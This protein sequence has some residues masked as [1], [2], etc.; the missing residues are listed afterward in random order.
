[1]WFW[2]KLQIFSHVWRGAVQLKET[3]G[4][5]AVTRRG[6][7]VPCYTCFSFKC[8]VIWFLLIIW[9]LL[10]TGLVKTLLCCNIVNIKQFLTRYVVSQTAVCWE[11]CYFNFCLEE[12]WNKEDSE[13]RKVFGRSVEEWLL[14]REKRRAALSNKGYYSRSFLF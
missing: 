13:D 9:V 6:R 14:K 8:G 7:Y 2:F 1:M 12:R 4:R 11:T 5:Y 10:H 3:F